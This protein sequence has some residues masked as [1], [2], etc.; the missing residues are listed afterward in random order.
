MGRTCVPAAST[1]RR[2]DVGAK[3]DARDRRQ[4]RLVR[5]CCSLSLLCLFTECQPVPR[6]P[7]RVLVA[8]QRT[9]PRQAAQGARTAVFDPTSKDPGPRSIQ[10]DRRVRA[11]WCVFLGV[12]PLF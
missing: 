6:R 8:G 12:S 11:G 9:G 10:N 4:H 5:S 1:L 7:A 3:R 2:E